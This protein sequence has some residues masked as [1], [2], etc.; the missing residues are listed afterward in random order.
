MDFLHR[1]PCGPHRSTLRSID[2]NVPD[3][4]RFGRANQQQ[5]QS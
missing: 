2:D 1:G 5:E 3:L 4:T